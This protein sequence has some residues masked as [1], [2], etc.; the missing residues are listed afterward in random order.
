MTNARF[1]NII[2]DFVWHAVNQRGIMNRDAII[3]AHEVQEVDGWMGEEY[4]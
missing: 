2:D 1:N 4:K 3:I